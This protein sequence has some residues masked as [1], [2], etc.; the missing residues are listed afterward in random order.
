[1]LAMSGIYRRLLDRID[2]DPQ[3]IL[4]RRVA[5]SAATKI[6]VA[7]RSLFGAGT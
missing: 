5:L 7:G 1:V 3:A 6:A 4:H 2:S